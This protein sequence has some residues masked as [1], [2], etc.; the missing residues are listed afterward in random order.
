VG[1]EGVRWFWA[2]V[3]VTELIFLEFVLAVSVRIEV[4]LSLAS[5]NASAVVARDC[6]VIAEATRLMTADLEFGFSLADGGGHLP[7]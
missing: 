1:L 4:L 3:G 6:F 2:F 7:G 5:N